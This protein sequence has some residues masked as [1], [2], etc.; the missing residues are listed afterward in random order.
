MSSRSVHTT[1]LP[2]EVPAQYNTPIDL[3]S[4]SLVFMN[5]VMQQP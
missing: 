3:I 1:K 4:R 2:I 5:F